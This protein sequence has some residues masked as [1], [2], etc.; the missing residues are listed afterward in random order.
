MG[1]RWAIQYAIAI[2]SVGVAAGL[3]R[4]LWNIAE[5]YPGPLLLAAVMA[6]AWYGGL[7]PGLLAALLAAAADSAL[8]PA[9]HGPVAAPFRPLPFIVFMSVSLL[10]TALNVSRRRA[11]QRSQFVLDQLEARIAQRTQELARVN[12]N[13]RHQ[14]VIGQ[15]SE[16]ELLAYQNRLRD[17]AREL[18]VAEERERHRVATRLHDDIGQTLSICQ[19]QLE[20]LRYSAP[21][22]VGESIGP[23]VDV[24]DQTIARTR[25]LTCE[26]SPPVLYELGLSAAIQWLAEQVQAHSGISIEVEGDPGQAPLSADLRSLLFQVTRELLANVAK[27]SRARNATVAIVADGEAIQLSVADDGV[28]FNRPTVLGTRGAKSKANSFGLFSIRER[29]RYFGGR[30]DVE[31]GPGE[32]SR[33]TVIV[34]VGTREP[35]V[36]G[37]NGDGAAVAS[38][39]AVPDATGL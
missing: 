19:M 33:L 11:H 28:G 4:L 9:V 34:P 32:G 1:V 26:L 38:V 7:G 12:E 14:I 23:I 22:S 25:T 21:P 15:Q 31:S 27:H 24:L 29:L 30:L 3:N 6:S 17:L 13:L 8:G 37:P 5:L 10:I 16:R 36:D 20:A 2:L 18:S 39:S 35:K